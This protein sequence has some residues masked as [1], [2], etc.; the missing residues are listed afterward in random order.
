VAA[1]ATVAPPYLTSEAIL[2]EVSTALA[3]PPARA[4]G[5]SVLNEIRSNPEITVVTIDRNLFDAAVALYE[6]RSDRSWGLTD[7][8]ILPNSAR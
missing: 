5:T 8:I 7:C 2:A 1:A 6:S 3:H 4:V